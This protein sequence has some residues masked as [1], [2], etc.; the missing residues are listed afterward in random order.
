MF[1]FSIVPSAAKEGF[2][3]TIDLCT[4]PPIKPKAKRDFRLRLLNA[5]R[6]FRY[7]ALYVKFLAGEPRGHNKE[8]FE[9]RMEPYATNVPFK[10]LMFGISQ[11]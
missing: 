9:F 2:K 8:I 11:G 1:K 5:K 10:D 3:F 7:I 4:N 6:D